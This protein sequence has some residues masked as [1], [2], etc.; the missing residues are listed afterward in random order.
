MTGKSEGRTEDQNS[1][2]LTK[3]RAKPGNRGQD[4]K[5]QNPLRDCQETCPRR[6]SG[7]P[8]VF[9]DQL[10]SSA[11]G[12]DTPIASARP[13]PTRSPAVNDPEAASGPNYPRRGRDCFLV[14]SPLRWQSHGKPG[15]F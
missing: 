14:R 8:D 1:E 11:G 6:V 3:K 4:A 9:L 7:E 12:G 15:T 2:V 10:P 5:S 13:F